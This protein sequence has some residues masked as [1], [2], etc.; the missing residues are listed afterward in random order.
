ML[1]EESLKELEAAKDALLKN[2][3]FYSPYIKQI[4]KVAKLKSEVDELKQ[5]NLLS[6]KR[7]L[8]HNICPTCGSV[9]HLKYTYIKHI[10]KRADIFVC[11][12]DETHKYQT[13]GYSVEG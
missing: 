3:K 11:T 1:I 2:K 10:K 12:K 4:D 6:R 5:H 9:I 8:A 7:M 13:N